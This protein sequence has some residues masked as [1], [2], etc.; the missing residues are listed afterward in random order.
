MKKIVVYT[1]LALTTVCVGQNYQAELED[2]FRTT[3]PLPESNTAF[4]AVV[5]SSML[6]VGL[7][8]RTKGHGRK[9]RRIK[10]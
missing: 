7:V 4:V 2:R 1:F 8:S 10:Y 6:M 5:V 9:K 3:I